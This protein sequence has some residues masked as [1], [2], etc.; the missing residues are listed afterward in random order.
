MLIVQLTDTHV[1]E[2]GHL[3]YGR[4][5]TNARLAT[6]VD[7]INAMD[8]VPDVAII[9]G[10]LVENGHPA[11]YV[12]CAELL[13][14]LSMPHYVVAGNHDIV[15]GIATAFGYIEELPGPDVASLDYVVDR[16]EVRL[17]ALDT[18]IP[19]EHG[20]NLSS[21]QLEW[22]DETLAAR[23]DAPTLV[24]MHH[25]PFISGIDWMDRSRLENSASLEEVVAR[26]AQIGAVVC[27]HLH[28]PIQA[29]F[30]GTVAMTSSSTSMQIALAL[31]ETHPYSMTN[32]DPAVTLHDWPTG[33]RLVTHRSV[34][35][36]GLEN[37]RAEWSLDL[38]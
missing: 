14:G 37:Y 18:S 15:A 26:H 13:S 12:L 25:P 4:F 10:D 11:E 17:V 2:P 36:D 35:K 19:G 9:T 38:G 30:G 27:G 34:I 21:G 32:E 7:H 28:R 3:Q 6:A 16:H 24:M 5:D 8:P 22:F 33:G 29:A 20:G 1:V 31:G 23:A